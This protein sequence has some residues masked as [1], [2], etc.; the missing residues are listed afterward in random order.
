MLME[1]NVESTSTP[2]KRIQRITR[3]TRIDRSAWKQ[4]RDSER[5]RGTKDATDATETVGSAIREFARNRSALIG[6]IRP[7][8]FQ[9]RLGFPQTPG[10]TMIPRPPALAE[11]AAGS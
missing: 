9:S 2:G 10:R 5:E 1:V 3:I 8:R 4:S 7:I 6:I 11:S